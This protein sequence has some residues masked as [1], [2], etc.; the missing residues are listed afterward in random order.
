M[1]GYCEGDRDGAELGKR[2]GTALGDSV[3][4][5]VGYIVS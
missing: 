4:W 1:L 5:I 2:D 3:G